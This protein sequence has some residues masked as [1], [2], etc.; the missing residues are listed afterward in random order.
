[1]TV[2]ILSKWQEQRP[3]TYPAN[4]AERHEAFTKFATNVATSQLPWLMP[5]LDEANATV[6]VSPS[7]F[8]FHLASRPGQWIEV[9][10]VSRHIAMLPWAEREEVAQ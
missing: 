3:T 9:P 7:L 6:Y 5:L 2:Q 8:V 10:E 1:M 4:D